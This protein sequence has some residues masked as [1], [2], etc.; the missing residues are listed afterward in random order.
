MSEKHLR[1]FLQDHAIGQITLAKDQTGISFRFLDSYKDMEQRPA[2]GQIFLD[3]LGA[4]HHQR[5]RLQAWFSNLLPEGILRELIAKQ[6]AV[7]TEREF[8]LLSY[9][10]EDLAG[11]VR[12]IPE[13]ADSSL[14]WAE[15]KRSEQSSETSNHDDEIRFSLAGVQLKFSATRKRQRLTIPAKGR[16]GN[17]I[18]KLPDQRFPNVPENEWSIMAWAKESGLTLPTIDLVPLRDIEGIPPSFHASKEGRAFVIER[19]DRTEK[20]RRIHIE[21]F[22]QIFDLYPQEKYKK[23]SYAAL[24]KL[25]A[26][27]TPVEDCEEFLRRLLFIV[28]SGN[29][30]AHHKNWSLIYPDGMTPRLSPAYDLVSTIHY[31]QD[32]T[33]ALN[34][35][36]SKLWRDISFDSFLK[37]IQKVEALQAHRDQ[38]T[39]LT[40]LHNT[41]TRIMDAW[42]TH[43]HTWMLR[44]EDK[45]R[46]AEHWKTLPLLRA[47]DLRRPP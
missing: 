2:L 10:G 46:L 26:A 32:D 33:L 18:V 11:A 7:H 38:S 40:F 8:F 24:L 30:D 35:A 42:T 9:L 31:I 17:W 19:F 21:D 6:A 39:W 12:V 41:T 44:D 16:G 43:H 47:F 45:Q 1:V 22:A 3:N 25:L 29:A 14:P 20:D 5:Q 36:G 15:T 23:Y 28:L 34:L 27:I 37:M 13:N 4:I